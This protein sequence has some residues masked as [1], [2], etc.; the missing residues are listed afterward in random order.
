MCG[1]ENKVRNKER[2]IPSVSDEEEGK[3]KEEMNRQNV[4]TQ[5][6]HKDKEK[7]KQCTAK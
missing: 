4:Q 3:E 1:S 7:R 2:D 6:G 5:G